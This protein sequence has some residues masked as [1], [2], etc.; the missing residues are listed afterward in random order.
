M[1]DPDQHGRLVLSF[2][3]ERRERL[4]RKSQLASSARRSRRALARMGVLLVAVGVALQS[5][6]REDACAGTHTGGDIV[7]GGIAR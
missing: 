3:A 7:V 1:V 6:G 2:V 4:R 5:R